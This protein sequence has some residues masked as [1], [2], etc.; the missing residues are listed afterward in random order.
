MVAAVLADVASAAH[1]DCCSMPA[2]D[3][4]LLIAARSFLLAA[5]SPA[6][7][8]LAC[9]VLD[10]VVLACIVLDFVGKSR[11]CFCSQVLELLPS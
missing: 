9:I 3:L 11:C 8:L 4:A 6:L 10:F 1:V 5:H 7:M 2:S